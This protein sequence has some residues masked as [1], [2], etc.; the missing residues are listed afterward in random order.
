MFALWNLT[1][2]ETAMWYSMKIL[3]LLFLSISL[4]ACRATNNNILTDEKNATHQQM[5][6]RIPSDVRQILGAI[7]ETALFPRLEHLAELAN[8][9]KAIKALGTKRDAI[10][11]ENIQQDISKLLLSNPINLCINHESGCP[12][13]AD[14]NSSASRIHP[15]TKAQISQTKI[16][17]SCL[18]QNRFDKDRTKS[19]IPEEL[20]FL[21]LKTAA[22]YF[23]KMHSWMQQRITMFDVKTMHKTFILGCGSYYNRDLAACTKELEAGEPIVMPEDFG[24]FILKTKAAEFCA[25]NGNRC[26]ISDSTYDPQGQRIVPL[27]PKKISAAEIDEFLEGVIRDLKNN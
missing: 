26:D 4:S 19:C 11:A 16:L 24:E 5:A 14:L 18:I 10:E 20:P 1:D 13:Q 27:P 23:I 3:I 9:I 21:E 6:Y 7:R 2:F 15:Y 22:L 17:L 25:P 8:A 12:N